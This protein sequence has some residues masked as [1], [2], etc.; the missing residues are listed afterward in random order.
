MAAWGKEGC[1]TPQDEEETGIWEECGK[2]EGRKD[3]WQP[4]TN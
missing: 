1:V 3:A 4:S 2:S